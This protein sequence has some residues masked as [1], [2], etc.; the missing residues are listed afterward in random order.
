MDERKIV[1][2]LGMTCCQWPEMLLT[3]FDKLF[4]FLKE[5]KYLRNLLKHAFDKKNK[6]LYLP[7]NRPLLLGRLLGQGLST[8]RKL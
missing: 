8:H 5:N 2:K 6:N 3:M 7:V 4:P 1:K